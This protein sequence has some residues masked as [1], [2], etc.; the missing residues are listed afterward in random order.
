MTWKALLLSLLAHYTGSVA[1]YVLTQPSS[2][3]VTPGQVARITCEGNNI[4]SYSVYWYQQKPAQSPLLIIYNDNNRPSGIPDRFTGSN[5]G[6]TATLTIS[7]TQAGDEADYYCQTSSASA[8]LGASA[9]LTCTLSSEHSNYYILW[10]QQRLG[11]SPQYVMK[12]NSDGSHS[13]GTG[14]SDCFTGSSS[15]A[16]RYLT[17]ANIQPEDEADYYCGEDHTIDGQSG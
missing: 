6:N 2:V 11:N 17:I 1:T 12:V 8:S 4:G 10:Y 3:S 5:S 9:T 15:G 13:K 14:I 7:G 16:N